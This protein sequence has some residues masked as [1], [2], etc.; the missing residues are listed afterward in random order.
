VNERL[1]S[2]PVSEQEQFFNRVCPDQ[3][4]IGPNKP[5]T[6]DWVLSRTRDGTKSNAPRELIHLFNCLREV[7]AK[8]LE[9]GDPPPDGEQLFARGNFKE[10][11]KAVSKVRLMQTLYAEYPTLKPYLEK[12]R[13]SKTL[14]TVN[15]LSVAWG[16]GKSEA[17]KRANEVAKSGFFEV[18]NPHTS[19]EYWVPFLYRD[20]LDLVQ[21]SADT[22]DT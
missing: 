16:V 4:D 7:Q 21:G 13:G 22:E 15:T 11:L 14:Q 20:A 6:F 18:R 8:H 12:L 19:T 1:S 2:D 3:V 5:H 17:E 9:V 10:A